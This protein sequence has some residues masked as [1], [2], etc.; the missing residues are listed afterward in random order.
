MM[1]LSEWITR[2]VLIL[3]VILSIYFSVNICL[4]SAKKIP[5]MKSVSQVT[6]AINE[7]AI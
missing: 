4:N 7:K 5:E 1:K 2:I 6:T 3:M